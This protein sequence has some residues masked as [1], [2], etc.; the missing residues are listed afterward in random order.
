MQVRFDP[1]QERKIA[2]V[3]QRLGVSPQD[4]VR[5]W[6]GERLEGYSFLDDASLPPVPP[7]P[8]AEGGTCRCPVCTSSRWSRGLCLRHYNRV[9]YFK[10][11]GMLDEEWLVSHGRMD[12]THGRPLAS[13]GEG[14]TPS[15]PPDQGDDTLWLFGKDVSL[16]E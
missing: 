13:Y 7:D 4:L 15:A 9:R 16:G 2:A 14:R 5:V 8:S 3:A 1:L 12:P 10:G 6:V 11:K